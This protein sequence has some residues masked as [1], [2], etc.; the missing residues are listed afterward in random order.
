M[1]IREAV[2]AAMEIKGISTHQIAKDLDVNQGNMVT[3][4]NKGTS[5]SLEKVESVIEYLGNINFV[6]KSGKRLAESIPAPDTA[7]SESPVAE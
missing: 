7:A 3:W 1:T 2:K 6:I 5:L 4:L